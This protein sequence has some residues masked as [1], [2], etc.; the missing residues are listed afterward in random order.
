M[1]YLKVFEDFDNL[2]YV[3][4]CEI[5]MQE[6]T[7]LISNYRNFEFEYEINN[8]G[9][10]A[11]LVTDEKTSIF[12]L[13]FEPLSL[14]RHVGDETFKDD[15]STLEEGLEVIENCLHT[16]MGIHESKR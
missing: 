10:N 8:S 1:K 13:Y 14:T 15:I 9:L 16:C 4:T 3:D 12:E 5:K 2:N 6:I 11:Q 7:D